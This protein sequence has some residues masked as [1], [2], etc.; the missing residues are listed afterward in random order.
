MLS[1]RAEFDTEV[2]TI[3][4]LDVQT[5]EMQTPPS[6]WPVN[7]KDRELLDAECKKESPAFRAG[8]T[9]KFTLFNRGKPLVCHLRKGC[10]RVV[11]GDL[12]QQRFGL[13][14]LLRAVH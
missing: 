13:V 8:H 11:L 1:A 9:S 2:R 6:G 5:I 4:D 14:G 3:A 7:R 12:L 10:V